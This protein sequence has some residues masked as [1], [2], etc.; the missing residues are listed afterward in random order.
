MAVLLEVDSATN[1]VLAEVSSAVARS[2]AADSASERTC[3][4][5]SHT[6]SSS[7]TGCRHQELS[8]D[9]AHPLNCIEESTLTLHAKNMLSQ[10]AKALPLHT[11]LTKLRGCAPARQ[12]RQAELADG[13]AAA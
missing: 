7:G 1:T 10:V 3:C 12:R 13:S 4:R 5:V 11:V 6:A 8:D 2:T 9:I